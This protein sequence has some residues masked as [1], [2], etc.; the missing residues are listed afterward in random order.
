MDTSEQT[1]PAG[2]FQPPQPVTQPV[3]GAP[4]PTTP[5]AVPHGPPPGTEPPKRKRGCLGCL[6]AGV[7]TSLVLLIALVAVYFA[8]I[9]PRLQ[10]YV[11]GE[12]RKAIENVEPGPTYDGDVVY[13]SF[14]EDEVN[15]RIAIPAQLDPYVSR[16]SVSLEQDRLLID[17]TVIGFSSQLSA[18]IS[19]DEDGGL[20]IHDVNPGWLIGLVLSGD[21]LATELSDSINRR[22]VQPTEIR[23]LAVQITDGQ[24]GFA[25][26]GK[27]R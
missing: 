20:Y 22:L 3:V 8:L 25:F 27:D 21:A 15:E 18:E 26:E 11:L 7:I 13:A 16:A 10:T 2:R 1:E 24:I 4:R 17:F 6:M 5:Q 14:T 23:I 19:A 9:R 12:I